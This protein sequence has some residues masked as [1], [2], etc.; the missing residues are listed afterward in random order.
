MIPYIIS[1][2]LSCSFAYMGTRNKIKEKKF[3]IWIVLAILFPSILAGARDEIV[4]TDTSIYGVPYFTYALARNFE[5]YMTTAGGDPLWL[6]L[7]YGL[8]R[9]T[10]D[11]FWELFLI[12]F[13][14]LFFTYKG[15]KQYDLGKDLWIGFLV[16]HIMFYSFTLNLMRQFVCLSIV[17]Y[18]FRFIKEQ[19]WIRYTLICCI[20]FFIQKTVIVAV[21]LYPMY[22]LTTGRY[23]NGFWHKIKLPYKKII[24]KSS[25]I[26]GSCGMVLLSNQWIKFCAKLFNSF[27]SQVN[28]LQ[29]YDIVW[30]NLIY[31]LPL[32]TLMLI[33]EKNI[34]KCNSDFEFFTLLLA[35]Y[36]TLWQL[37]GISRES[38]RISFY[39]GYFII[40]SIPILIKNVVGKNNRVII[41][42]LISLFMIVFYVDYFV[43]NLYNRTYPYTST[44][45]GIK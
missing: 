13:I 28:N 25:I 44:L 22:H 5:S 35:I 7:V 26:F 18:C 40:A 14:I 27:A 3:N 37:Q 11:V 16:F 9:I 20:L 38:Y 36:I 8:T 29:E 34:S 23:A 21:L 32:L 15:L 4:G 19:K 43:I 31:M 41:F 12:E 33:Y 24:F 45:L 30:R 10:T 17:F 1:A 39:F 2:V 42:C 6:I